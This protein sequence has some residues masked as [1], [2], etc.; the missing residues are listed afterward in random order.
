MFMVIDGL[1]NH[2]QRDRVVWRVKAE[3]GKR[4]GV[5]R[6]EFRV[7]VD[8]PSKDSTHSIPSLEIE[9]RDRVQKGVLRT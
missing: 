6:E 7:D 5:F 1:Q 4:K 8:T 3:G 9:R 2:K